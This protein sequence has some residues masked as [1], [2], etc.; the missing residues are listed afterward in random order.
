MEWIVLVAIGFAAGSLGALAGL[1]GG[2]VIVPSLLFL[3]TSTALLTTISPQQAVG[4]S[5][6]TMIFTG[7]SSTLAYMKYK[8]VDYKSGLLFFIG[9]GPG[10][11]VGAIVNKELSTHS[12]YVYFGIFM[13]V[14]A[15]VLIFR[16]KIKPLPSRKTK[17]VTREFIERDGKVYTYS[18]QS[19][20]AICIAFIV[21]FCSGIFGIGGGALMVPAMILLFAFPPHVAVAT[22]MFMIFLSAMVSS[23]THVALGNVLW[24]YAVL[25]VPG[26]WVGAKFGAFLNTRLQSNALVMV[27]RIILILMGIRLIYEGLA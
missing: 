7:L 13:I 27:L 1:G 5:L 24:L 25:L 22:S 15:I 3:G 21:G 17:G 19:G 10:G 12:F 18:F 2:I 23:V 8:T 16:S 11:I 9:S 4:T 6:V 20:T 14:M 26:A